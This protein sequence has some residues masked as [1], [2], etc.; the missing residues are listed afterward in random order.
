MDVSPGPV[1]LS[2]KNNSKIECEKDVYIQHGEKKFNKENYFKWSKTREKEKKQ[3]TKFKNRTTEI[4]L[5]IAV[6]LY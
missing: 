5:H 2:R 6:I 1:F 4:M 3:S